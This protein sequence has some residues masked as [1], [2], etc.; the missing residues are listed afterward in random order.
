MWYHR[1][2]W[3]TGNKSIWFNSLLPE[4]VI[5]IV[6]IDNTKYLKTIEWKKK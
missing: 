5:R 3:N 2:V 1:Y 4:D 6:K